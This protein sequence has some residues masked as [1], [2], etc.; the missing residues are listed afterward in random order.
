M[1]ID[2]AFGCFFGLMV[3][4]VAGGEYIKMLQ[5]KGWYHWPD[6]IAPP[7]TGSETERE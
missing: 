3:G 6:G 7:P 5:R 1:S 2:W 4:L